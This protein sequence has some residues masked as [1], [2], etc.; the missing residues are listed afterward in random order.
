MHPLLTH[1]IFP[2][3]HPPPPIPTARAAL[4]VAL[5]PGGQ[6]PKDWRYFDGEVTISAMEEQVELLNSLQRPKK[7]GG[8]W[9]QGGK[10]VQRMAGR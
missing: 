5:P 10:G 1:S 8:G 6:A 7:V 4:T 9:M 3:P 2:P